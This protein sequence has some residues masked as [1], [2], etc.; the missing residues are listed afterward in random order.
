MFST[1]GFT[2]VISMMHSVP[3]SEIHVQVPI[4][5]TMHPVA[6][7]GSAGSACGDCTGGCDY[8]GCS[9][10]CGGLFRV[11]LVDWVALIGLVVV[12]AVVGRLLLS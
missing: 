5:F 9:D 12:V 11:V 3:S 1:V 4:P 2:V 6:T 7:S 8:P 10:Y